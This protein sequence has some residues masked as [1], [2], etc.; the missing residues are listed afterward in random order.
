MAQA[1]AFLETS[2]TCKPL[3][4]REIYL[5]PSNTHTSYKGMMLLPASYILLTS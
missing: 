3:Y 5:L 4:F 2:L 1:T